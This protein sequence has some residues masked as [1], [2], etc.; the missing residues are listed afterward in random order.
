MGLASGLIALSTISVSAHVEMEMVAVRCIVIGTENGAKA[1]AGAVMDRGEELH[2]PATAFPVIL[3]RD[4]A[5]V[6]EYESGNVDRIGVRVL[7][8][9]ARPGDIAATV[10]AHGLNPLEIAAEIF[11]GRAL[12]GIFGPGGKFAGQFAFDRTEIGNISTDIEQLDTVDLAAPAAELAVGQGREADVRL[13][14]IAETLASRGCRIERSQASR[15]LRPLRLATAAC[16]NC[17]TSA[18]QQRA[19]TQ[20]SDGPPATSNIQFD[21]HDERNDRRWLN[22]G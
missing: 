19:E 8:Q 18:K 21:I 5:T 10:A 2:F 13:A 11:A 1:L 7:R 15:G 16:R 12:D 3:D 14:K 20:K 9:F 4:P 17:S 6:S 22:S